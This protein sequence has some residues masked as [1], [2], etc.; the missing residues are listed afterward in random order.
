MGRLKIESKDGE[1]IF[2]HLPMISKLRLLFLI[3]WTTERTIKK[4]EV[5]SK[6]ITL[7]WWSLDCIKTSKSWLGF[8]KNLCLW[9]LINQFQA[10]NL[11]NKIGPLW[12][13]KSVTK[14]WKF[15]CKV[16]ILQKIDFNFSLRWWIWEIIS[17]NKLASL[18]F[19]ENKLSGLIWI[20]LQRSTVTKRLSNA[21][22]K[23]MI[24]KKSW[25]TSPQ[26]FCLRK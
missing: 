26:D 22:I 6:E 1:R 13:N 5:T 15:W 25:V 7:P 9:I 18:V 16:K 12:D 17:I 11:M 24:S 19:T 8:A 20:F 14:P 21:S 3:D 23:S 2:M 10:K 4:V